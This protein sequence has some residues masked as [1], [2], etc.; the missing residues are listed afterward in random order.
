MSESASGEADSGTSASGKDSSVE[1]PTCGRTDFK[2]KKGMRQHHKRTHG[3]SIAK[4]TLTCHTCG[5]EFKRWKS[6][7]G[8]PPYYC[9]TQCHLENHNKS[10][11]ESPR[12][13]QRTVPCGYC[14]DP[15][16]KP[17]SRIER[18][19]DVHCSRECADNHH[20]ERV[21]KDG[22]PNYRHGESKTLKYGPLWSERR[23]QALRRDQY[24]CQ[25]CGLTDAESRERFGA[26]LSVHHRTPFVEFESRENAHEL[27]NLVS[28]CKECHHTIEHWPVQP[29]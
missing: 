17:K 16:S 27:D 20:S 5:D 28:V 10:G 4:T 23:K 11:K 1:C 22:N 6:Q 7:L 8:T 12:Y 9:S 15:V 29:T 25:R 21:S 24:R 13:S 19:T 2:S 14:G 3:E 18:N 26:E